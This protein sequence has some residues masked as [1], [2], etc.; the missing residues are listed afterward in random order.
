MK[1]MNERYSV[2][3]IINKSQLEQ[4]KKHYSSF[5]EENKG[6]YIEF[7]AKKE[8]TIIIVYSSKKKEEYKL[9]FIGS[10]PL[11]E[12]LLWD[13]NAKINDKKIKN[14]K[15]KARWLYLDDQIGSDEVGTGDVFGPITV[16]ASLIRKEDIPFL[17]ELG[18]D[19]SKKL[20]DKEILRIGAI[21]IKR[22]P[23][24][25]LSLDN[26][27]YNKLIDKGINLNEMKAKMH[28]QALLNLKKK[29][30]N[31]TSF[32]VDQFAE[33]EIYYRYLNDTKEVVKNITF[34]TKGES[35]FP[36]VAV[37]SII[38][39]Y[40]F[41]KKMEKINET[42]KIEVPFGASNRVSKFAKDFAKK[43]GKD[44]LLKIAKKNFANLK[45]II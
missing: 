22:I 9:M 10:D 26:E 17:K 7:F 2:T 30:Q 42:Y 15:E 32:F 12:A 27:K 37:S 45:D 41:L 25:Q 40:S 16:A 44:E 36:C 34:K 39:R 19:D 28:N 8:G 35:Y 5:Q 21:L 29:Y 18:V 33:K 6:D 38:A 11:K 24:S 13:K 31:V 20:S 14:K 3:L 1:N 4:I 43:Y 23:Y